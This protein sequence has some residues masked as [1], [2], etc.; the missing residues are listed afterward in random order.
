M[1]AVA[2]GIGY[3]VMVAFGIAVTCGVV[4]G[5]ATLMNKAQHALVD[6]IGGWK[7]F[8]EYRDW[9]HNQ[10]DKTSDKK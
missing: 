6:S 4:I 9:L 1:D 5:V 7:V 2:I 8:L 3:T 10:R